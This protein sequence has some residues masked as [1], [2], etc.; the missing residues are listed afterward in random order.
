MQPNQQ[1]N[2]Q[3]SQA[4]PKDL[5]EQAKKL[6]AAGDVFEASKRAGKLRAHFPEEPPIL[7][8]HG[9]AL[10]KLGVHEPAIQDMRASARLTLQALEEGDEENP[11]RPRIVDQFIHLQSEIGRSLTALGEYEAAKDEI[12]RAIDMDPDRADAVAAMAELKSAQ[13]DT[14]EAIEMIDDGLERKL[15]EIPLMVSLALI[16][17]DAESPDMDRIKACKD[18]LGV[19]CDE[20]GLMAGELMGILRAHGNL[21]D[22][23]G[24]Y[25][26]A[27]NSFRRAAKLRRGGF[28]PKAH[29]TIT[30]KLMESW[31]AEGIDSLVRPEGDLGVRRVFLGGSV[32]SGMPQVQELLERLPNTVIVGPMES[33]GMLCMTQ[34]TSA[35]GVLRAVVPGPAGHRG[36]QLSKVATVYGQTCDAAARMAGMI[37]VDTHPHNLNLFGCAAMSMRGVRIINC[38]RDPIEHA[39]AMYCDEMPGNHPYAGELL[40]AAAYIKDC[41]RMMDHWTSV[42]NDERV[43]AKVVN[44]QYEQVLSD[45]AAVLRQLGDAL[46]FEVS[47]DLADGLEATSA[48]GPGLHALE[49]GTA[50]KQLREFFEA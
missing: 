9:L 31:T 26:E 33:L 6:M 35:K 32:H 4:T 44:V 40:A 7:A 19:L 2:P 11:A 47:D 28:N 24:E 22:R 8:I 49:Y 10:A 16:L 14:Q 38:R 46:G 15:D 21:S 12:Q 23:L 1:M 17:D 36:D 43:G 29:A 18:R 42:L 3:Q 45:P 41:E 27:F 34:L 25:T 13:G 48:K 20:V 39:L 37:T 30:S 5:F 50:S